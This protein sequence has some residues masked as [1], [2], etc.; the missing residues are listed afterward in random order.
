M[1][2]IKYTYGDTTA[3]E[4]TLPVDLTDADTVSFHMT[5][6]DGA[7]I[8]DGDAIVLDVEGGVVA[9][10]FNA[11]ETESLGTHYIEWEVTWASGDVET[12]PHGA[13]DT[14]YIYSDLA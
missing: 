13:A 11:G 6:D 5:D 7:V 12:F 2:D 4:A 9:Y 3:L 8:V 14:L 10:N 1:T